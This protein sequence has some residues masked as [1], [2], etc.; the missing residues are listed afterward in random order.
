MKKEMEKSK[1]D[2]AREVLEDRKEKVVYD[3]EVMML[4]FGIVSYHQRREN[5]LG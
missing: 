3:T 5:G 2:L 1:G 4:R